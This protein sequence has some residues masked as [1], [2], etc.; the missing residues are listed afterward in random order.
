[1]NKKVKLFVAAVYLISMIAGGLIYVLKDTFQHN[2]ML[3]Q[4]FFSVILMI[5]PAIVAFIIEKKDVKTF[6]RYYNL[7]L[8]KI[9]IRMLLKYLVIFNLV[10][11]VVYII[12]QY[13]IG[14][15]FQVPGFGKLL[16]LDLI[17]PQFKDILPESR[18]LS[19]PILLL[20]FFIINTLSGI[21]LNG[22]IALGEEIGWR[23]FMEKHLSFPFF[24]KNI[25]IGVI[26]GLWH[27][28][29]IFN[30]HNYPSHPFW[31][32]ITMCVLC[33]IV[34]FYFSYI[35]KKSNSLYLIGILH[36]SFNAYA[37][38]FSE[39]MIIQ[40]GNDLFNGVGVIMCITILI[41]FLTDFF[42]NGKDNLRNS[43]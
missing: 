24:K 22:L 27:A 41:V 10:I 33:I 35:L 15:V 13:L 9:R 6:I 19:I 2:A 3:I 20:V 14:N 5:T 29:L 17:V 31:G 4:I 11:P 28:P 34:S 1:M 37:A 38:V 30:G 18:A 12:F 16:D 40:N 36:G 23:G 7:S 8:K 21:T 26:W 39:K 42:I 32:I 43:G 25:I